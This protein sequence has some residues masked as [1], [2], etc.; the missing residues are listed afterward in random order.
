M[1]RMRH[2]SLRNRRLSPYTRRAALLAAATTLGLV[3][4]PATAQAS[5]R[6]DAPLAVTAGICNKVSAS[7]V[8][9]ILGY[10]VPAA[11]P[12]TDSNVFD[13]K[14]GISGSVT[15]CTYGAETS[16]KSL[17]KVAFLSY[18]VISKPIALGTIK[19]D[20]KAAEKKVGT[21][22]SVKT[23]KGLHYPAL[24]L[25]FQEAGTSFTIIEAIDGTKF[26]GAGLYG[27]Q[28]V[29][30]IAALAKLAMAAYL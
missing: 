12:L 17:Q 22:F 8:S 16:L 7:T 29:S 20:I 1:L 10:T 9:S 30:T 27:N 13:K 18:E 4:L 15:D 26:A 19:S 25:H 2:T 14:L 3:V 5:P 11:K 21:G 23:Y 6:S 24:K 28:P